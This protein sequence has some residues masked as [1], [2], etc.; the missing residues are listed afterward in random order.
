[1]RTERILVLTEKE[2]EE[3]GISHHSAAHI[4]EGLL[5]V[6]Y[7]AAEREFDEHFAEFLMEYRPDLVFLAL[8]EA[9]W[10]YGP[11]QGF[12]EML[13][14]PWTGSGVA[15]S[16]IGRDRA[17]ARKMMSFDE[18]PVPEYAIIN[19][20]DYLECERIQDDLLSYPGL[21]LVVKTA[22]R[23]RGMP[24]C[25]VSK[26]EELKRALKN[27]F[28]HDSLLLVEKYIA[29]VAVSVAVIGNREA[30]LLPALE[31]LP[32][33]GGGSRPL[34]SPDRAPRLTMELMRKVESLAQASFERLGCRGV[35]RID[36]VADE[37]HQRAYALEIDVM[38]DM[39][40][41]GLLAQAVRASGM[42][43]EEFVDRVVRLGLQA[44]PSE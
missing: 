13:G 19:Q 17:L 31:V 33:E 36:I 40:V 1:M 25:L 42:S 6:G 21:P 5:N 18:I 41:P 15:A 34:R 44:R 12:L 9:S 28:E 27:A 14:I 16:A 10:R 43:W 22:R 39:T 26:P 3:D 2:P 4:L 24:D 29:G 8:N 23:V 37:A 30:Y 7:E 11:I 35:A 38:P 32:A 20:V